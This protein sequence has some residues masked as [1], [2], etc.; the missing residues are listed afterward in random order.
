MLQSVSQTVPTLGVCLGMQGMG[1]YFGG[2]VIHAKEPMHGK[3]SQIEHDG[4][5]IFENLPQGLEVMMVPFVDC[6]WKH[7]CHRA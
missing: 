1:Y 2:R 7:L 3:T 5:G 6:R 4:K